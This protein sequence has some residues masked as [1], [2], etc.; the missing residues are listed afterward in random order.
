[1][2]TE[3][4][5][6]VAAYN[7][8]VQLGILDSLTHPLQQWIAD[9]NYPSFNSAQKDVQA[10]TTRINT[11]RARIDGP[12]AIDLNN[13]RDYVDFGLSPDNYPG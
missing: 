6:A 8:Q 10:I 9:R 5:A 1:M 4:T 7:K 13:D 12:R 3:G 2:I 11:I